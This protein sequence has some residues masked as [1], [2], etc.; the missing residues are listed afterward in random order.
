MKTF[1]HLISMPWSPIDSASIQNGG[2]KAYLNHKFGAAVPVRTYSPFLGI[3]RA[4]DEEKCFELFDSYSG[5]GEYLYFLCY[6]RRFG[7]PRTTLRGNDLADLIKRLNKS[8]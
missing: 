1:V 5:Y 3:L 4:V 6:L 7:L 2:L 8:N